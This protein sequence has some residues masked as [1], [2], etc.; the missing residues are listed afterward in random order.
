MEL[1]YWG[2]PGKYLT[3][4]L[5]VIEGLP[6]F[7]RFWPVCVSTVP[8]IDWIT[9]QRHWLGEIA[10]AR[11]DASN[12]KRRKHE[13]VVSDIR[14]EAEVEETEKQGGYF[15][16]NCS[17]VILEDPKPI[18]VKNMAKPGVDRRDLSKRS[19]HMTGL[20]IRDWFH[21]CVVSASTK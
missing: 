7:P 18:T 15:C 17:S 8:R 21:D 5:I 11:Y 16:A 14:L 13:E 2:A 20:I 9:G 1:T 3:I 19:I 6:K 10:P 12:D 4:G